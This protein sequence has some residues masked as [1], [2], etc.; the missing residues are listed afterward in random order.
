MCS[1]LANPMEVSASSINTLHWG[2]LNSLTPG[3]CS[4]FY[5]KLVCVTRIAPMV[6]STAN[7]LPPLASSSKVH[8]P[9]TRPP[10]H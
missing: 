1:K 2:L 10:C 7:T 5:L 6:M 9:Y 8:Y 3:E 4:E